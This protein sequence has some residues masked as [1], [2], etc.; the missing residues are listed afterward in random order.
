MMITARSVLFACALFL[1]ATGCNESESDSTGQA[2]TYRV[3]TVLTGLEHPWGMVFLPGA[4]PLALVT[5][6]P[7]RLNLVDITRGSRTQVTGLPQIAAAGQ[8]G[9]LD[10]ALHPDF[11]ENRLVYLSY[12]AAGESRGQ[13]ATHVCR[14]RLDAGEAAL[15]DV[16]VILVAEP[17]V[18]T[19]AHFGSRL[20]FDSQKRLYVTAG[21]RRNRHS[22]QDLTSLHGKT[23][24]IHDDGSIPADNPFIDAKDVHP[25][26][27]SYGHRNSQGMARHPETG[28]IWQC[29]HGEFGG[30]EIN[31]LVKGGNFGWPIATYAREYISRR[32]IGALPPERDDTIAPIYYWEADAFPPSGM[33]FY[34]GD[35]FKNWRGNLF[36]G[37]L[38]E[39]CLA[40]FEINGR[41]VVKAECLLEDR[42][43][44]IRDVKVNPDDGF[45]Y[46]LVDAENAPLVKIMPAKGD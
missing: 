38:K 5:E 16:E 39:R 34:K 18:G 31:I 28:E 32:T 30:D 15:S 1:F 45:L 19:E 40:R 9:L 13:F 17:F 11:E 12:A 42:G 22:A 33:A 29:E 10:V 2:A 4:N 26:I 20:V 36:V 41:R 23:L 21:D 27:Y 6:R 7:G 8:G 44:R 43:W 3:D 24:R 37:G 35:A 25:A 14:G 46:V